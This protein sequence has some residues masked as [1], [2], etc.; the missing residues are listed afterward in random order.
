R[1]LYALRS[2]GT[3]LR[4]ALQAG[5]MPIVQ[6]LLAASPRNVERVLNLYRVQALSEDGMRHLLDNI[7]GEPYLAL[8]A[9]LYGS[10]PAFLQTIVR[11]HNVPH[12]RKLVKAGVDINAAIS[13]RWQVGPFGRRY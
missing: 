6:K 2:T 11:G 12:V 8:V 13:D 5:D 1:T 3:L 7:Q 9:G 10:V 4:Q